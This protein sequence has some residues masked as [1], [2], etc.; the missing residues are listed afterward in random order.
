L[1]LFL[2]PLSSLQAAIPSDHIRSVEDGMSDRLTWGHESLQLDFEWS[3][4]RGPSLTCIK[5]R[6]GQSHRIDAGLPLVDVLTVSEGH[7][8]ASSRLVH[9]VVGSELRY[10]GHDVWEAASIHG[11][12]LR[13]VAEGVEVVLS[14]TSHAGTSA[15][16]AQALVRNITA[17]RAQIL[18]SVTS[19]STYLGRAGASQEVS[20]WSLTHGSSDWL[21]EGRWSADP[22]S[23]LLPSIAAELT[24]HNPRGCFAAASHGGWSTSG[25]QPVAVLSSEAERFAWAWEVQHNGGWR[26]EI[27]IDN[28]DAYFSTSGPTDQ[29]HQWTI[30]LQPGDSFTTVPVTIAVATDLVGAVAELTSHRRAARRSHPDRLAIPSVFNDYMNTVNGDPTSEKLIPLIDAAAS[31]GA[32][33]FCI[34]AG[35]YDDSHDWWD[36]VGEWVPSST[37]FDGGLEALISRIRDAGMTPGLWL[38]PEVIGVN[39][40]MA[41]RLP[42]SAFLV[43]NGQ[44]VV[45]QDR[46][47][48]DLRDPAAI[49]HLNSVV[50]RL[51][52]DFGIGYFKLDYNINPGA[53]TDRDTSSV[54]AGL[55]DH[56]RAH[57]AWLDSIL[58]RYPDL[59]LENCAS[60]AMRMDFAML[61]RLQLQS[62][63]DQQDP[64]RYPP[65]A[66]S[67]PLSMTPEQAANWAYPQPSMTD[68]EIGFTLATAVLGRFYLSGWIDQM[69]DGQLDLVRQAVQLNSTLREVITTGF[70]EWPMGLPRWDSPS[71]ALG[72]ATQTSR[73]VTIWNRSDE[74]QDAVLKFPDLIGADVAVRTVFPTALTEWTTQ[75]DR[76]T[77]TLRVRNPTGSVGAR[78]LYLA[79]AGAES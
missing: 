51:V 35:W 10:A 22:I 24:G 70:P 23:A 74:E 58:D 4:D 76:D 32:Q 36:S 8:A 27:G 41:G 49:A 77:G 37:R 39:S 66:A 47:H 53:G 42:D 44:R 79:K 2:K 46:Y 69:G 54:G 72:L 50:D 7:S 67:A 15:F 52:T 20:D 59:I 57:L 3:D 9:T 45:E 64:M 13:L 18:R 62:T 40:T 28:A 43:R 19:F 11:L 75:W 61:S 14:L 56:N 33:I 68:E 38:E 73:F 21:A 34:D 26:W 17:S 1:R 30:V 65:I 25:D 31:V 78:I 6:N 71:V 60:G 63:S 29:D 12:E 5:G 55:L 48:L 16:G